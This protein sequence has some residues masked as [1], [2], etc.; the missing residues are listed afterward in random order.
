MN[1]EVSE[2][3]RERIIKPGGVRRISVAVLVNGIVAPD[4]AGEAVWAPRPE[5]E[6]ARM[7]ELV[8]S[9][10]GFDPARGDT[11]T[12]QSLEFSA[13][14]AQGTTAEAEVPSIFERHA[15]HFAQLFVLGAIVLALIF[16]VLRPMLARSKAAALPEL[17][18]PT[19]DPVRVLKGPAPLAGD[20]LVL[21]AA[22][23]SKI[24]RLREV[25]AGRGEDS[26]AVLRN[27][28]EAP[29]STKETAR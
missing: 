21:P 28:I 27:W 7:R 23:V 1:F 6:I 18:G 11:V 3:R 9:A 22:S 26:A 16:F 12:I 19:A 4:A 10:I 15:P 13:S 14:Q 2:T 25:I 20:I 5:E 29:D 24:D 8:Q 17:A